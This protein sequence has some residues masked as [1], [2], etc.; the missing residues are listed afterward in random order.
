[1]DVKLCAFCFLINCC[2]VC[3]A[4][5]SFSAN[6]ETRDHW[7]KL[8]TSELKKAKQIKPN[9]AVAKNVI[10]FLGD[11]MGVSTVTAARILKGQLNNKTGEEEILSFEEFP[12]V[13]LSKTYCQDAQ[14]AGSAGTATA[15]FSGVKTNLGAL[16][17]DARTRKGEC[18]SMT[19]GSKL[20]G[21][22]HWSLDAGKSVG[23]VTTTRVTHATPAALYA[24]TP[25][26]KWESDADFDEGAGNCTDIA[27]QLIDD[28]IDIQ[29]ILGGGREKFMKNNTYDPQ[30]GLLTKGRR[31][32]RDLIQ[33]WQQKQ[34]DLGRKY[35]YVW[36]MTEFKDVDPGK[37]DY[38]FGLFSKDDMKF[39]IDRNKEE[40]SLAEM[41]EKAIRILSKNKK[42]FFL[43]VEGGRID[44]GHHFA[45]AV[46]AL[47]ETLAFADAVEM[48]VSKTSKEDTLIITTADHSHVFTIGGYPTRGNPLFGLTQSPAGRNTLAIDN[49]P[50][51]TLNYANGPGAYADVNA[52]VRPNLTNVDTDLEYWN[53]PSRNIQ[54]GKLNS[55]LTQHNCRDKRSEDDLQRQFRKHYALSWMYYHFSFD[56]VK[57]RKVHTTLSDKDYRI[58]SGVKLKSETHGGEDV[59]IYAQGPM[60]HL[61]HG[62][63]EQNYIAHVMAYASC[64]GGYSSQDSCAAS[65]VQE[66]NSGLFLESNVV[67]LEFA[68]WIRMF[69]F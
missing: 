59:A 20:K 14:T 23:L 53:H 65:D 68:V 44:H 45:Q 66:I 22:L 5:Y 58:Q 15:I 28:N 1:M 46:R 61:F 42:G 26:R 69:V 27:S 38:L 12:H 24:H 8:A 9:I 51:T 62:V 31:D 43:L 63:H 48:G 2:L 13:G 33:E 3:A 11:G 16:G 10:V 36:N 35:R 6:G 32:N 30:S 40:P 57:V 39:E 41:T 25:E 18:A 21:I 55:T 54:A 7:N 64:V 29:V 34:A 52:T 37:T 17:C 49:K 47:H 67:V 19:P 4:E 56:C 50:F 60:A